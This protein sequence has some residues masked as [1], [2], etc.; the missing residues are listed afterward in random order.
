MDPWKDLPGWRTEFRWG[1]A[2]PVAVALLIPLLPVLFVVM[3][4][5]WVRG[6][7]CRIR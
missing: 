7:P 3:L 4:I 6:I 5:D 2:T 1:A